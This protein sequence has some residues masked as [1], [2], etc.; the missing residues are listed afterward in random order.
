MEGLPV[1]ITAS[2]EVEAENLITN[3]KNKTLQGNC[4]LE[5]GTCIIFYIQELDKDGGVIDSVW[6]VLSRTIACHCIEEHEKTWMERIVRH[7]F[8]YT[9]DADVNAILLYSEQLME[10]KGMDPTEKARTTSR[11]EREHLLASLIKPFLRE[12]HRIH[13]EGFVRFRAIPYLEKLRDLIEYAIDEFIMD[14]QYQDFINLLKYFVYVQ[15]AKIPLAHLVHNGNY[16]FILLDQEWQPIET[17]MSEGVVLE[18]LEQDLGY[19]DMIVSTLITVSPARIKIHTNEKDTQVIKTI[20]HIF[21]GRV[22]LC[23]YSP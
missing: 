10:E 18:M 2:S 15:E 21:E 16:D 8:G 23:E 4:R 6:D 5:A 12:Q 22:E 19:E 7:E 1:S 20:L 17:S 3:L 14:K 11:E 13:P 9:A